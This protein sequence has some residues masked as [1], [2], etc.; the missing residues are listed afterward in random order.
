MLFYELINY[1]GKFCSPRRITILHSSHSTFYRLKGGSLDT[2]NGCCQMLWT[3]LKKNTKVSLLEGINMNTG[4]CIEAWLL[5]DSKMLNSFFICIQKHYELGINFESRER[6]QT[7][8]VKWLLFY[9]SLS[10]T[11][12]LQKLMA[13]CELWVTEGE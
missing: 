2:F 4:K 1:F 11:S 10:A 12:G 7:F 8:Q 6:F 9:I 3:I 13:P 5:G